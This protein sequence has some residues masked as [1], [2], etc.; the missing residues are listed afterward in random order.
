[1]LQPV[2]FARSPQPQGMRGTSSLA[3]TSAPPVQEIS[4]RVA[5]SEGRSG[6][7][8]KP[9]PPG[10]Q[11]FATCSKHSEVVFAMLRTRNGKFFHHSWEMHR[12]VPDPCEL[13]STLSDP[14]CPQTLKHNEFLPA[15]LCFS[16]HP[17]LVPGAIKNCV[18][19][20]STKG[21]HPFLKLADGDVA[22]LRPH[23]RGA[24]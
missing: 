12:D 3:Q 22:A 7:A 13:W 10:P 11:P 20:H 8:D 18:L 19:L 15:C 21:L 9:V 5:V 23:H 4:L 2:G 16:L 24:S 1:M 6:S 17:C 14:G